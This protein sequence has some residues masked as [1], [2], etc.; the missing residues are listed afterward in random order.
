MSTIRNDAITANPDAVAQIHSALERWSAAVRDKDLAAIMA[1][2]HPDV[3]A[4]DAIVQLQFKGRDAYRTHWEYCLNMC[5]GPML[6]QQRELVI[7]AG[8]TVA[9]AHWLNHCGAADESGEMKGSWMRG[10]AGYLLTAEGW[11]A[12]HEHFSAPFDMESGKAL[13][14]LNP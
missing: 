14:D 4:Y 3:V 12:I 7:H 9:F 2:Y 11:K 10:S 5:E 1:Y 6:F 13:F 8:D